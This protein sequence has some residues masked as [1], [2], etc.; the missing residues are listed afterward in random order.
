[1]PKTRSFPSAVVVSA[2]GL[3]LVGCTARSATSAPT[4]TTARS[5]PTTTEA[6]TTTTTTE[7]PGWTV[8]TMDRGAI[9]VDSQSVTEPDGH[10]VTIFRFRSGQTR[11]GLHVGSTD[12]P[13]G[14]ATVGPDSGPTVGP[15]EAPTLVSVFNGGFEVGAGAGGF[16]LNGQTL[17]PLVTGDAS[18]VIDA[19]GSARVGVWGQGLPASGEQVV[20]VRQNLPPLV[21]G[22]APSAE[23]AT[24]GAWGATLG[25]GSAVA[26][27]ALGED[28]SG[29]V[30]Y[31]AGMVALP[32][33]MAGA[34]AGAGVVTAMELDIN[35]EWVQLDSAPAPGA[36]LVAGIPGQN[37]PP[38]QYQVGWT[39]DFV[40]VMAAH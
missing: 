9:A 28:A 23:V 2:L 18:L 38:N 16:E 25:G 10:V 4:A 40:T 20:S 22:G 7:Q 36:P 17:V 1:M 30:L 19:D 3:L 33:D 15:D 27:S 13:T 37:R 21:T 39:R 6:P 8:V 24:I 35:P 34:L 32:S 5:A 31:A 11:F 12:P 26:R 29:N 14:T